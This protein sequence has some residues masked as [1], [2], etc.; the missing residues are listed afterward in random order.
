MLGYGGGERD[1]VITE[2]VGFWGLY[3]RAMMEDPVVG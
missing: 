1:L 2:N 3:Y